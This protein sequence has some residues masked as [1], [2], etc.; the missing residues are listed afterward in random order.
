MKDLTDYT[1]EEISDEL[2][3]RTNGHVLITMENGVIDGERVDKNLYWFSEGR[4]LAVGL[5]EWTKYRILLGN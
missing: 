2:A 3:R 5:L 1:T 4:A